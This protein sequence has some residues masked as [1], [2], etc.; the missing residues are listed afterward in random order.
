AGVND[1]AR[2][3]VKSTHALVASSGIGSPHDRVICAIGGR[4]PRRTLTGLAHV[5]RRNYR[6]RGCGSKFVSGNSVAGSTKNKICALTC[7]IGGSRL[8][9]NRSSHLRRRNRRGD[10]AEITTIE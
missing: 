7:A 1:C 6:R 3:P 2:V 8:S 10:P 4:H 5:P 9:S